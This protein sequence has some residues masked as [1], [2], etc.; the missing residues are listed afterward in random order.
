MQSRVEDLQLNQAMRG[1]D[2]LKDDAMAHLPDQLIA[3][4]S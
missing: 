1:R 2:E 4:D 3:P